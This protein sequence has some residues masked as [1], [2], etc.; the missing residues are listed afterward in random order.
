MSPRSIPAP[1][2][3]VEPVSQFAR[4]TS[5]LLAEVT[6]AVDLALRDPPV[7]LDDLSIDVRLGRQARGQ[8]W[9]SH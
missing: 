8:L 9:P 6:P 4:V 1:V 7:G 3:E 2:L 5:E